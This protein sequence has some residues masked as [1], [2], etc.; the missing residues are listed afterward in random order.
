M[1][2]ICFSDYACPYCYIGEMRLARAIRELGV[3]DKVQIR[4]KAFE[5]DP[6]A[7]KTVQSDTASRFA[8]KYRLSIED[9]KA[10]IEHISQLG[11]E[12]GI[13]FQY[14]KAQYTN[15][16][17]A[18]RLMK[19]AISKNDP[20]IAHK[21]NTYLFDAYFTKSLKLADES[22]L[23]AV[24]I[25]AGLDEKETLQMLGTSEFGE[26]VR[27]DE[28]EA[29]K[30]GIHGVPYF[31]FENGLTIPGAASVEDLKKILSDGLGMEKKSWSVHSC[32]PDGCQL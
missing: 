13:D 4:L 1:Q 16:F 25:L 3:I 9:A 2:I 18:H 22:T 23:V 32:G 20:E 27:K 26:A 12:E 30:L 24:A 17:D 31:I 19:F 6:T 11:Q 5:L 15:T 21:T 29:A 14:A 8:R 10:R 7:P 28:E